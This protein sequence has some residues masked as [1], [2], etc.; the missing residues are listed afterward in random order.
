MSS[1][2]SSFSTP[3]SVILRR[4]R[5]NLP[6]AK[7]FFSSIDRYEYEVEKTKIIFCLMLMDVF[8]GINLGEKFFDRIKHDLRYEDIESTATDKLRSECVYWERLRTSQDIE[9]TIGILRE[10]LKEIYR[11]TPEFKVSFQRINRSAVEEFKRD[12]TESI[13]KFGHIYLAGYT[14]VALYIVAAIEYE[15]IEEAYQLKKV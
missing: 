3:V 12:T 1:D 9:E 6:E 7:L 10:L 2:S 15:D 8:L 5:D 14:N 4:L 11:L 13:N